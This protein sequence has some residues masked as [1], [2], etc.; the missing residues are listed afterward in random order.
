ML[1][2]F[3]KSPGLPDTPSYRDAHASKNIHIDHE[4]NVKNIQKSPGIGQESLKILK[5]RV[6][7]LIFFGIFLVVLTY[8]LRFKK[9]IWC[10][11]IFFYQ[12]LLSH[13]FSTAHWASK[14]GHLA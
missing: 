10:T 12:D 14:G 11:T 7:F 9:N 2:Y 8:I 3:D 4:K 6:F 5:A 1:I 13:S